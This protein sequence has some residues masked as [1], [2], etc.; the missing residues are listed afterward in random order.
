MTSRLYCKK[1][2]IV[3]MKSPK[4]LSCI[5]E[6]EKE[7]ILDEWNKTNV[8]CPLDKAIAELFLQQVEYYSERQA[9]SDKD[10]SLTYQQL[11][12]RLESIGALFT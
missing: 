11:N 12:E 2:F 5:T 6:T 10:S 1:C 7:Q 9:V 4:S 8:K 3:P